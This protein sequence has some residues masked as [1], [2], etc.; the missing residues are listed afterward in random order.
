VFSKGIPASLKH[1]GFDLNVKRFGRRNS[2]SMATELMPREEA[3]LS[4]NLST[5]GT[6]VHRKEGE[7][8]KDA[9]R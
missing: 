2:P 6:K 9:T 3:V 7:R 1:W 5:N 4:E 8:E